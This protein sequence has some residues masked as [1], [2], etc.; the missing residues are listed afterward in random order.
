MGFFG[1]IGSFFKNDVLGGIKSV[2]GSIFKGVVQPLYNDVAKPLLNNVV[3]PVISTAVNTAG[4]VG[5]AVLNK[6]DKLADTGISSFGNIMNTL[7]NPIVLIGG[8]AV[9]AIILT[10]I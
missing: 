2:T 5:G 6:V 7:S 9:G 8:L 1:S 3:K 4:K 10:K